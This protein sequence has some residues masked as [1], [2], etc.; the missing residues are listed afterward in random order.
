MDSAGHTSKSNA[1]VSGKISA[2]L[3]SVICVSFN[4]WQVNVEKLMASCRTFIL[5]ER[6]RQKSADD[7]IEPAKVT[8]WCGTCKK[9][10]QLGLIA[11]RR[12]SAA[13]NY[14]NGRSVHGREDFDS[15]YRTGKLS[16][17]ISRLSWWRKARLVD[18]RLLMVPFWWKWDTWNVAIDDVA[19]AKAV[20]I[21]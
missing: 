17:F 18:V 10:F 7:K 13:L 16:V 8:L 9:L 4:K 5:D 20:W 6:D 21:W 15:F 12:S 3:F 1:I 2:A 11:S 14:Q 19:D